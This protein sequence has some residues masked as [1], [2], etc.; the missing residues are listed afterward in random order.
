MILTAIYDK[1]K[2]QQKRIQR[3][4]PDDKN[5]FMSQI[6]THIY[7]GIKHFPE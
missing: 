7:T 4:E 3:S 2:K 6:Q 1:A 5:R